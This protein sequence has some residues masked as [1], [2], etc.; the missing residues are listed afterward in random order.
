MCVVSA[1]DPDDV[2]EGMNAKFTY[3]I[4][5]NVLHERS[6]EAIFAIHAETGLVRT[7]LC[8]LDRE[9]TPEYRI[10]VVATD[11][12]ALKGMFGFHGTFG[13][14]FFSLVVASSHSY[15]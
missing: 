8:C 3:S 6:G 1:W 4:E 10:Q 15:R 11:G 9:S 5:K 14:I 12:G 2:S 7:A 13:T